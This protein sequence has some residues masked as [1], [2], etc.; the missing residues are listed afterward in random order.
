MLKNIVNQKVYIDFDIVVDDKVWLTFS[1]QPIVKQID[2]I[3]EVVSTE[4][5]K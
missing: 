1:R 3:Q 4:V 2:V 5:S